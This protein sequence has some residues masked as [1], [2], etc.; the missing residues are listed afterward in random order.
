MKKLFKYI[1][2]ISCFCLISMNT[3]SQ[4]KWTLEKCIEYAKQHRKQQ[5][6]CLCIIL[7]IVGIILA[8]LAM[9]GAF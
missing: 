2:I 6:I 8:V 9:Q 5:C 1:I 3:F 7:I 4:K